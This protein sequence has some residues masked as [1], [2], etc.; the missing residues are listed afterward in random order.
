MPEKSAG[1]DHVIT[2]AAVDRAGGRYGAEVCGG[3]WADVELGTTR[4]EGR[5]ACGV[6]GAEAVRQSASLYRAR[7]VSGLGE[8]TDA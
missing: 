2:A 4:R 8:G 7:T 6:G 1:N 3:C 5:R